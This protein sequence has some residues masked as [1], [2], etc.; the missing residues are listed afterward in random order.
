M[1]KRSLNREDG[2]PPKLAKQHG[3]TAHCVNAN[4]LSCDLA[5]DNALK[6][7]VEAAQDDLCRA[8]C[9]HMTCTRFATH[10][11]LCAELPEQKEV[12]GLH[13]HVEEGEGQGDD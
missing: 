3:V 13:R 2:D 4:K 11:V 12:G 9:L 6:K 1:L 8:F 7:I 5:S 10:R